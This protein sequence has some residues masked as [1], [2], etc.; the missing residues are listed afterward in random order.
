MKTEKYF[1]PLTHLEE[2]AKHIK[3]ATYLI[4]YWFI[5]LILLQSILRVTP[6]LNF[7]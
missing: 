1:S 3:I 5:G 7:S 6:T 4:T 2:V